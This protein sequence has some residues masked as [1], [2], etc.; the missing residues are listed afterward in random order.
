MTCNRHSIRGHVYII[1]DVDYFTKWAEAMPTFD[2]T[3]KTATLFIFNHIITRFGV[4][5]AIIIDND[6]HF[7]NFMMSKLTKKL[8][9]R[10]ENSTPYYP[11]AN[12]QV[13]VINKVLIT[14]LRWMRG[15][16][17][18]NWHTMLFS[19]LWAY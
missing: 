13:E 9:L 7:Q 18:T 19:T 1:V 12:G 3:R 4:P 6:S 11:Q 5:Q 10:H 15:I 14:M 8:G 2:N 16:H 17:K